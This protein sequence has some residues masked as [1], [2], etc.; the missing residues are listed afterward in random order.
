[1][2]NKQSH[3]PTPWEMDMENPTEPKY[4]IQ[5]KTGI[6]IAE[7]SSDASN[8]EAFANATYIVKAVNAHEKLV[9]ASKAILNEL[10]NLRD[11]EPSKW[12]ELVSIE[13]CNAWDLLKNAL[14]LAEKGE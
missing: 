2:K 10:R 7:V 1:M 6:Y 5:S 12:N 9:E 13:L 3:T 8:E 4:Y 14:A 11:D